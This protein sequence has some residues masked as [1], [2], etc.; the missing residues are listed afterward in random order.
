MGELMPMANEIESDIVAYLQA[1]HFVDAD[2]ITDDATL[3]DL[4]LD[5]LGVLAIGDI[6]ETKYG[7]SIDDERIAAVRTYADFKN[8][9]SMKQAKL[10][11][12]EQAG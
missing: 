10:P 5:S 12:A 2:E 11:T 6:L 4:G 8:F 3:S 1:H 9:I 7:I